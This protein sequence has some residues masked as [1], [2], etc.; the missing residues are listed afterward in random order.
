MPH[1]KDDDKKKQDH[2]A[3]RQQKNVLKEK[4]AE[5]RGE[6]QYSKKTNHL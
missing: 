1:T 6:R 2:N 3:Q 4:N 5:Q